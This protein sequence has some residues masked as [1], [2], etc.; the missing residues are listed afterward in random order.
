MQQNQSKR[1]IDHNGWLEVPDNPISK[2]GVFDYL[3]SEI[4][5]PDPNKIYKVY[6]PAEELS[7][8]ECISSFRLLPF[9]ND[10]EF[11]GSED[12]GAMPA[13]RKGIQGVIGERLYFAD[14]FLR[15]N[16]KVLSTAA[17]GL[18]DSGKIDLSPGYRCKY[19]FTPGVFEGQRYDAVQRCIRGNHLALVDEGR[20]GP[21]V[22]VQDHIMKITIDSAELLPMADENKTPESGDNLAQIKALLEQLKPLLASQAEANALLAEM[23]LT[24][25][26]EPAVDEDPEPIAPAADEDPEP[27]PAPAADEDPIATDEDPELKAADKAILKA[28]D[29]ISKRLGALELSSKGMDAALITNIADRDALASK[30]SGFVGTFDHSRMTAQAVAEY[31]VKKLGVPAQKGS[32]RIALDAYLH[33]RTPAHKAQTIALDSAG[34]DL[35]ADYGS[36]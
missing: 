6:R 28:L 16:I 3:G 2:V 10:H 20:T 13:E 29:G 1:I 11:L 22:A 17:Q 15:G 19:E 26:A 34:V 7:D 4:G 8:P 14:P 30:L 23:G 27:A 9:V 5:A 21:D 36:N 25:P 18:I 24:P 12:L 31:G 32:E 33:G 35:L